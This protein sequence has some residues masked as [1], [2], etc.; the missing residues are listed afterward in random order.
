MTPIE[1]LLNV[2][3]DIERRSFTLDEPRNYEQSVLLSV[4]L[5]PST[6]STCSIAAAHPETASV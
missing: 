4:S 5:F 3:Q 6:G 2:L 1:S